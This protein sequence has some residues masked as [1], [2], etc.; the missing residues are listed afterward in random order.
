MD[1]TWEGVVFIW[2]LLLWPI[3]VGGFYLA[4]KKGTIT[5]KGKFFFVSVAVGYVVLL[6]GNLLGPVFLFGVLKA[7]G[8]TVISPEAEPL[9]NTLTAIIMAILFLFP[10]FSTH[11]LSKRFS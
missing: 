9:V 1:V 5:R 7:T 3:L 10:V 4:W 2:A 8:N 6:L 11:Y